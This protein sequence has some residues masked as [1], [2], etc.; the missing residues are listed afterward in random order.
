[1]RMHVSFVVAAL[2]ALTASLQVPFHASV[3]EGLDLPQYRV[4]LEWCRTNGLYVPYKL[5]LDERDG[6]RG[7][8]ALEDVPAGGTL[9]SV[10]EHVILN[11]VVLRNNGWEAICSSVG[12]TEAHVQL[13]TYLLH[14][15]FV[16]GEQSF[17]APF[18]NVMPEVP[19]AAGLW[20]DDELAAAAAH[21]PALH[22]T[23]MQ[24]RRAL[25]LEFAAFRDK[26]VARTPQVWNVTTAAS[27]PI[28]FRAYCWARENVR[29]RNFILNRFPNDGGTGNSLLPLADLFN[30]QLHVDPNDT[31]AFVNPAAWR[32]AVNRFQLF[33]LPAGAVSKGNQ[34]FVSYGF[35]S[36][37]TFLNNYGTASIASFLQ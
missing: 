15:R 4:F 26:F 1:M 22:A 17:W 12:V 37:A 11:S 32:M 21:L 31:D 24:R 33:V 16:T 30:H 27:A 23:L 28:D 36:M 35:K 7:F 25:E 10:P 2:I 5:E 18:I 19:W 8:F 6:L 14:E 13:A 34:V 29:S 3:N 20:T 9:V